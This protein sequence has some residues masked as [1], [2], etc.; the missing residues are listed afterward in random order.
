M[1]ILVLLSVMAAVAATDFSN[2]MPVIDFGKCTTI[3]VSKGASKA[4]APMVTHTSDC[5]ECDFRINKIPAMDHPEGSKRTL[6]EY[7]SSYPATV[8]TERG[9]EGVGTWHPSNLEGTT[10]QITTWKAGTAITGTIP[11]V[12]HTYALIEGGYGMGN[13]HQ[14]MIGEST[15][16]SKLFAFPTT[17]GGKAQIEVR[18]LSRLALERTKTAREAIEL[19]GKFGEE[20]GFYSCDWSGGD[21]SRGEGGETLTVADTEEAWVFHI[22][23]DDTGASAVWVAEQVPEGEVTAVANQFVIRTVDPKRRGKDLLYSDNIFEVAKRAGFWNGKGPLDFTST[24]APPRAH[25]P[26]ATRRVWR[27]FNLVAPSLNIPSHTDPLATN[28]PF[29]V[30]TEELLTPQ[31]LMAINRDHYE[32]TEFDLTKGLAAGPYGD[33]TR[34]DPAPVD[35]MVMK[36]VLNGSFERPIAMFRTSTSVVSE[37]RGSM[38]REI[39]A[40]IWLSQYNPSSSS[41]LPVYPSA[42]GSLPAAY[43]RG[44]LFQYDTSI[45]FWNFCAVGNYAARFYMHAMQEVQQVQKG[46]EAL[47]FES[48]ATAE[49]SALRLLKNGDHSGAMNSLNEVTNTLSGAIQ[50]AWINLLPSMITKFHD[51]YHAESL[52]EATINMKKLFYPKEWLEQVGYFKQKPNNVPGMIWFSPNPSLETTTGTYPS[53]WYTLLVFLMGIVLGAWFVKRKN[54]YEG[55]SELSTLP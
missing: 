35:G 6:Y 25:A 43:T 26:Y 9:G 23:P 24:Y 29:S 46:L 7:R 21:A 48:A 33:P 17:Q 52:S 1:R 12:A 28:Y 45:A 39:G 55:Y 50:A 37:A 51:G 3:A 14:V 15:C 4:G 5:A 22:I 31:D 16:A 34:F 13:E 41:Y 54:K 36:E 38:P 8:S 42:S 19:M 27:V 32:G 49:A 2:N 40:R 30:K 11:Q 20:L 44:S 53:V 47:A 18:E 10:E